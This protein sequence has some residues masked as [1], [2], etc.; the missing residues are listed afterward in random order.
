MNIIKE[1][2]KYFTVYITTNLING[3]KYI[4]MHATNNLED[5]YLGSGFLLKKAIKKYGKESFKKEILYVFDNFEEM[6]KTEKNL[7]NENVMNNDNYYNLKQGGEGGVYSEYVKRK[8]SKKATGRKPSDETIKKGLET[9]KRNGNWYKFGK[10]HPMFGKTHS[11]ETLEVISKKLKQKHKDGHK[12]WNDGIS[13]SEIYTEE[14]RKEMYGRNMKKEVNPSYGSK[15]LGNEV[16]GLKCY[17]K[18]G[19]NDLEEK[20]K[21]KGW[22]EKPKNFNSLKSVTKT[23]EEYL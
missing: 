3:K 11:P 1:N 17:I 20:L 10:D 16:L 8:I 19:N 23:I 9:R 13:L 7:C 6:A 14:E 21:E 22:V 18:K 15:W 4:G 12:V 2:F 5:G